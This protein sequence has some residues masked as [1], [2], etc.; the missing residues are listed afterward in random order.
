MKKLIPLALTLSFV[1]ALTV[2]ATATTENLN[3]PTETR[4][5]ISIIFLE[6]VNIVIEIFV[7]IIF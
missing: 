7:P 3:K 4:S 5:V 1:L 6:L 2:S